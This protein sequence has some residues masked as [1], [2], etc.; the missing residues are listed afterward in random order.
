MVGGNFP[1]DIL[2]EVGDIEGF[3]RGVI[4]GHGAGRGGRVFEGYPYPGIIR[5]VV[6]VLLNR[7][8]GRVLRCPSCTFVRHLVSSHTNVRA[9]LVEVRFLS[10][11]SSSLQGI[12]SV[13]KEGKMFAVA[14]GPRLIEDPPDEVK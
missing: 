9:D 5:G 3:I 7:G 6:A 1:L 13:V 14:Q 4:R 8:V 10:P 12:K 11:V 2:S